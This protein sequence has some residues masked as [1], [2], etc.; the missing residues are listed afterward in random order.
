L[1]QRTYDW[2]MS[3]SAKPNA[4]WA[5]AAI[6]FIESSVFPI[7]PDV[8]LIP[9][10]LAARTRWLK[11]A[12]ICTIASVLGGMLGYALGFYLYEGIGKPLLE[13]YG[14]A[15]KFTQFQGRYNEW[16][17][18]IVFMA[19]VTPFP[20]K[21]ITI[22]SGV[23]HLDVTTFTVAS[24][25]ARGLRFF[26]VA[27]LLWWI[28]DPIRAFIEKRLGLVFTVFVVLLIG[29]FVAIKYIA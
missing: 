25:L 28:G 19:G 4:V 13:F 12:L 24:I 22:A 7:P 26:I 1:L 11:I 9:M 18:W 15:D 3:L 29:G 23:T 17:A 5:L 16:G 27:A 20:Y 14:Y 6:A 2:V 10:V 21:V 8:L